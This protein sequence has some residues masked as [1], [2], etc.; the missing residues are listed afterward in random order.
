MIYY[1]SRTAVFLFL[2][3]FFSLKIKGLDNIP[4]RGK[5]IIASNH[6]SYL[7]PLAAGSACKRNIYYMAK[8]ELFRNKFFAWYLNK[9]NVFPV[10]RYVNDPRA[11]REAIRKLKKGQ[12]LMVF[13]EGTRTKDGQLQEGKI[14][15]S[16]LSYLANAP[17]VP[18]Y[19]KGSFDI[20]PKDASLRYKGKISVLYGEPIQP[21]F[22]NEDTK[23]SDYAEFAAK[24]MS[25]IKSLKEQL[26]HG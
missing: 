18:C 15:I 5:F 21:L 26:S 7:D 8:E 12:G 22:I 17:V 24:V 2:K 14:G 3:I 19:V 23:K 13:P 11:L 25:S 1:I 20:W 4:K 9:I 10:R 6:A 16:V